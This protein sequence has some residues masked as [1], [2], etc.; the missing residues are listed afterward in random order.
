MCQSSISES[1]S[2]DQGTEIYKDHDIK[3]KQ[4]D[5]TALYMYM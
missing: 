2:N 4:C 5:K 3:I 1:T